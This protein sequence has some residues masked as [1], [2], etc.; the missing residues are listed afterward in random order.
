MLGRDPR[1]ET[2][3]SQHQTKLLLRPFLKTWQD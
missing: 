2:A 1:S 3:A